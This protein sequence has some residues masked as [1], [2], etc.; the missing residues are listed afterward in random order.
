MVVYIVLMYAVHPKTVDRLLIKPESSA[1]TL[2]TKL[3]LN[4]LNSIAAM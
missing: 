3:R 4:N 1:L 2:L